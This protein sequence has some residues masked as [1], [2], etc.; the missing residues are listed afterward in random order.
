ML[1]CGAAVATINVMEEEGIVEQS[2][3]TG[4]ELLGP[5]LRALAERHPSVGEVRGLGTFWALELVRSKETRE[6]LVPYNAAGADN[7]PMAEFGAA[8]KK[9]G[10]WPLIAGNRIHV[11]PPCNIT[12]QDVAKGLA[13]LDEALSVADA[14]TV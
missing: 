2:A 7:A 5:G 4:A 8:C 12:P 3:R 13:I 11:A 1:A 6:P 14:H 9:G 10:L